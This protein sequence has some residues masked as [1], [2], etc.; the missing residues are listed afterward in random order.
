MLPFV[1]ADRSSWAPGTR[2]SGGDAGGSLVAK[3]HHLQCCHLC[4]RTDPAAHRALGL[5]A[6]PQEAHW[7]PVVF[8]Y[9]VWKAS[10]TVAH[11]RVRGAGVAGLQ[12]L[13]YRW[14]MD[15]Q[16]CRGRGLHRCRLRGPHPR[17]GGSVARVARWHQCV[18]HLQGSHAR[19]ECPSLGHL[20]V[21]NNIIW[22]SVGLPRA[23]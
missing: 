15:S 21:G 8:T 18:R 1:P 10:G 12:R 14:L 3:C 19:E 20:P 13:V 6:A 4:P 9:G 23:G 22:R 17:D 16:A 7:P 11:R 2:P 5:L